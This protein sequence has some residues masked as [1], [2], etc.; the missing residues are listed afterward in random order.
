P[1]VRALRRVGMEAE[2]DLQFLPASA[3][4][5]KK[6]RST[7]EHDC[8]L[9]GPVE[10]VLEGL[11][12]QMHSSTQPTKVRVFLLEHRSAAFVASETCAL[13]SARR[14]EDDGCQIV[15]AAEMRRVL[16]TRSY[17]GRTRVGAVSPSMPTSHAT[18]RR[19]EASG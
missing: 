14:N 7:I 6:T 17:A 9:G 15:E 2:G 18:T 8:I 13:P 16:S 12:Q 3:G 1:L 4:L 10:E 11:G 19:A 5:V